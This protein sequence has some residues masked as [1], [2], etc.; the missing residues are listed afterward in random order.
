MLDIALIREKPDWVKEQL[1]KLY[2]PPALV[3]VDAV[4]DI[5]KL[6]RELLIQSERLQAGRNKI[7]KASGMLRGDKKLT[8]ADKIARALGAVA[9]IKNEDIDG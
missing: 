8:D 4:I 3:R 5:D 1:G 2:D 6:R 7:N 9:F